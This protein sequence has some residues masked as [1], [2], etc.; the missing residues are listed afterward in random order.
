MPDYLRLIDTN[1]SPRCDVTPLFGDYAAFTALI[2]DL[3]ARFDGATIDVVAGIDALGFI[4]GA[5]LALHFKTGFIPVRKGGKLPVKA[6]RAEFVDYT[7]QRKALELRVGAVRPGARVLLVDEWIETG[8]QAR[9]AIE[10][11]ERQGG[12]VAG[13]AAINIDVNDNTHPLL[14]QYNCQAAMPLE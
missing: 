9:A 3:A 8:A 11:I 10:L 1:T 12:I 13:V 6:D 7:G 2:A 14:A 4:L 5:A